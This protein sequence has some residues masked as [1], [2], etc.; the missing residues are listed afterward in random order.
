MFDVDCPPPET[1]RD[2]AFIRRSVLVYI[3]C[4]VKFF[5]DH[6]A[7]PLL[8]LRLELMFG[9]ED[10]WSLGRTGKSSKPIALQRNGSDILI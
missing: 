10:F 8:F 2:M 1:Q 9:D 5:S 7:D 3:G 4:G 6:P